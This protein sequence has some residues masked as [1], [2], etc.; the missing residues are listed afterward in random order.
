MQALKVSGNRRFLVHE[1]GTP[2]FWLGDTAWQLLH[3]C[4]RDEVELYLQDRAAKRFNVIQTVILAELGGLDTPSSNGALPLHGND[5]TRPNEAYF[6]FIDWV[7]QRAGEL[8]F[9]IALLPTWGDKWNQ[10]WG[11]GPEIFTPENATI[12]GEWLGRRYRNTANIIWIVG[13]DRPVETGT[14]REIIDNMALGLRRGDGGRH[15]ISFHPPGHQSSSGFVQDAEWLDFNLYQTGHTRAKWSYDFIARDYALTPVRP[16]LDG[17]PGY[18]NIPLELKTGEVL[19]AAE[20]VRHFAYWSLF[21]GGFGHTYGCSEIWQMWKPGREAVISATMPWTESLQLPGAGQMQHARALLESRPFL[22]RVPD[23]NLILEGEGTG[24]ERAVA[25]RDSEGSYALIY[26]PQG[27]PL[28]IDLSPLNGEH[29]T[30]HWF[31][32]RNGEA[33]RAD[34]VTGLR[35]A[36][37]TPPV[38]GEDWVL[39]IDETGQSF[40][41][42]GS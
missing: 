7:I 16:C 36:E 37:F 20:D 28:T 22:T 40:G 42:P 13:G 21:A 23:P 41:P 3:R 19:L 26:S 29:F 2:F 32:P 18:E 24:S 12:Y 38:A 10:K 6:A 9:Y 25:C 5:P 30:I 4:D 1:D 11:A 17:E 14:H 35:S 15:L 31:N 8:G 39:V 33:I 34:N 27:A